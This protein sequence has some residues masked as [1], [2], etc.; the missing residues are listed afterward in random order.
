[1]QSLPHLYRVAAKAATAGDVELSATGLAPMRSASPAEFDGPG[2]RWSP[3]TLLV[4]A[5]ADCLILTFRA[6]AKASNVPW[7]SLE[8]DARGTLDRVERVTQF[9]RIDVHAHLTVPPG[10]DPELARLALVKAEKN[11]LISNSLKAAVVLET[12]VTV[13]AEAE[14]TAST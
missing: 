11:C 7:V 6:V 12:H 3:E 5:V 14:L 2:D 13:A 9:V 8:C 10:T 4:G 1:M